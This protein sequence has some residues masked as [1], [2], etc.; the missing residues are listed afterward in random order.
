MANW[1][2]T[3]LAND[4]QGIEHT[5]PYFKH[6]RYYCQSLGR[7]YNNNDRQG[8]SPVFSFWVDSQAATASD[9]KSDTTVSQVRVLFYPPYVEIGEVV[10]TM[11]CERIMQECKSLI[12]TQIIYQAHLIAICSHRQV[13]KSQLFQGYIAGSNPTG[14]TICRLSSEAEQRSVKPQVRGSNPLQD[15]NFQS[16]LNNSLT[17]SFYFCIIII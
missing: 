9:C 3:V 13:V 6:A 14:S 1:N 12:S 5:M 17:N 7:T 16:L 10:N 11:R 4:Y 2:I 15:A 8:V